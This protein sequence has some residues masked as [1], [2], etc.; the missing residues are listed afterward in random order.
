VVKDIVDKH[1]IENIIH[2]DK[3]QIKPP[4]KCTNIDNSQFTVIH[5]IHDLNYYRFYSTHS[6]DG[7]NY[8]LVPSSKIMLMTQTREFLFK[9]RQYEIYIIKEFNEIVYSKINNF[10]NETDEDEFVCFMIPNETEY[11]K[12]SAVIRSEIYFKHKIIRPSNYF[13]SLPPPYIDLPP[14]EYSDPP[15]EYIEQPTP[16]APPKTLD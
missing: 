2:A 14:P 7:K 13:D 16:S 11:I 6:T 5:P 10:I 1:K 12:I 15:P 4:I 9:N 8:C 3:I